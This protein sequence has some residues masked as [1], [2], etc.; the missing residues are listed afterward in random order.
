MY[1]KMFTIIFHGFALEKGKSWHIFMYKNLQKGSV[2]VKFKNLESRGKLLLG[3]ARLLY[4]NLF[5]TRNFVSSRF[6]DG[7]NSEK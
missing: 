3:V 6:N 2:S 4:T 1:H 5:V 7:V